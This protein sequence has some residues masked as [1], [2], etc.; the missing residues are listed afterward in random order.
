MTNE[1]LIRFN[2]L[3]RDNGAQP[4][5]SNFLASEFTEAVALVIIELSEQQNQIKRME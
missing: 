3:L 2:R 4:L 1:T 5:S